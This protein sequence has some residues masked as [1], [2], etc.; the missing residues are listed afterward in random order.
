MDIK[1]F[2]KQNKDRIY[3][4]NQGTYHKAYEL[5]GAHLTEEDGKKGV[6]FSVWVPG[7]KAVSVAGDFN[8]WNGEAMPLKPVGN[9]GIWTGFAEGA[10]E[11]QTYKY[12]ITTDNGQSFVKADPYAF[13]SE[14]RPK[15]ASVIHGLSYQWND[16]A[17]MEKRAA[18][19]HFK[20]PF[21][22]YEVHLQGAGKDSC[23]LRQKDG[24]HP[25]GSA[26]RHGASL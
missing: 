22:I 2:T 14:M 8:Y 9:S 23:A 6:R 21:N 24:I 12:A 26:S 17:W 1:Q 16:S 13:W 10:C 19:D 3:L 5:L 11:G 15:T 4:F 7:A 20:S 18:K 25:H